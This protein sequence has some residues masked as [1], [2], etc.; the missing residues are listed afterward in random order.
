MNSTVGS[1][2]LMG[3]RTEPRDHHG[4]MV[5]IRPASA[6][7][8]V[9]LAELW[10]YR[11][12]FFFLVWRDIKSRYSQTV[13]GA[14]WAVVQPV[15]SMIIFTVIFGRF[16]KIPS[17]GVPYQVFSL[18]ALVPWTYFSTAL[19]ASSNSLITHTALV[20]KVYFPRLVIPS[21]AV[22]GAMVDFIISFAVLLILMLSYGIV[23]R[24]LAI[25]LVPVLVCLTTITAI[26]MGCWLSALN[27]QF[28]DFRHITPFLVQV[29]MFG[30]P[31]VYPLSLVPEQYRLLYSMNPMAGA[32]SAFR[33]VLLGTTPIPWPE[34]G[35]SF[36][37]ALVLLFTGA[38]YFR[39]TERI[40][41]DVA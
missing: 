34:L 23:A 25:L 12:L 37:G 19:T 16:A 40:F 22:L 32:I 8:K 13:L 17:D 11:S 6:W 28:R 3:E 26:G 21:A 38:L 4:G 7:P 18:T 15:L 9:D 1:L 14:G 30:S 20:T 35:V 27:I 33:S 2:P 24:P 36:V 29:W 10:A 39:R 5:E 41:A 31:I